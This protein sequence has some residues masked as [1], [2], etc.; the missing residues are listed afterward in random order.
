MGYCRASAHRRFGTRLTYDLVPVH[1]SG[2]YRCCSR[3]G[4]SAVH[5]PLLG[6]GGAA[7]L[8]SRRRYALSEA[9][10][11]GQTSSDSWCH[12]LRPAS[13]VARY[14]VG[15][16]RSRNRSK[17]GIGSPLASGRDGTSV[18]ASS[19]NWSATSRL[20]LQHRYGRNRVDDRTAISSVGPAFFWPCWPET[21]GPVVFHPAVGD[22]RP[23]G[24]RSG[25]GTSPTTVA[26]WP[27]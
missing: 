27:I 9:A 8:L 4:R 19:P 1:S 6:L 22:A 3:Q 26:S 12:L 24:L 5:R 10:C 21:I 20:P 25:A 16:G 13:L 14:V 23:I 2:H 18:A 15:V 11:S 17:L 7:L